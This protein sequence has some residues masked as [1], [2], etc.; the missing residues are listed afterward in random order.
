MTDSPSFNQPLTI[1]PSVARQ[2]GLRRLIL[3]V[4]VPLIAALVTLVV[5]LHGGRYVS[6]DN[7][8]V[9]ASKAPISSQVAGTI[10]EVLVREN[11]SVP[12]GQVLFRLDPHPFQVA[13]ARAEANLAQT[14]TDLLA[15]KASYRE[16]QVEIA[17]ARTRHAFAV[18]EQGRESE[19]AAGHYIPET[20]LDASRLNTDLTAQQI[21]ALQEDLKRIAESLG[22]GVGDPVEQHP[23]Y[24][25]AVADLEQAK[26][27]LA[28]VEVRAPMAGTVNKQPTP[29]QYLAAGDMAMVLVVSGNP[30][31][32]A[33]LT[34]KD[35]THVHPGQSVTIHVDT[36]PG[37][38]WKGMV[39]SLSPATGSEFSIIPAQNATGNWVKIAQ[40]VAVRIKL[41]AS[42]SLP[43]LRSGLSAEVKIDTGHRRRLLGFTV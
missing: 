8:Y 23:R 10:Q 35:L 19:L 37:A 42:P 32:E 41:D 27:D 21:T 30:W 2:R 4:V 9:E 11:Q 43:R 6:T 28:H 33:N 13:V 38:A 14:R 39:E 16:K 3:L 36:Y 22:G 1:V 31:V 34:E 40:R 15:L 26:L 20:T 24:R 5:Y 12:A 29:G 17:L 18:K 7:A 25:M